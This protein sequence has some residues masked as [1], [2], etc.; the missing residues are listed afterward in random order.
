MQ[1]KLFSIGVVAMFAAV[2]VFALAGTAS[3][4]NFGNCAK[5]KA[6]GEGAGSTCGT[7]HVFEAYAAGEPLSL[8]TKKA[9]ATGNFELQNETT[10]ANGIVCTAL[11]GQGIM[12]NTGGNA[13]SG[14]TLVFEKCKGL[15]ALAFCQ[16]PVAGTAQ[17]LN[18]TEKIEGAVSS[19]AISSTETEVTPT[20][21]N[22]A[23]TGGAEKAGPLGE[24][25]VD[26]GEVTGKIVGHTVAAKQ[27]ELEFNKAKGEK[28]A[29]ENSTQTGTSEQAEAYKPTEKI[30]QK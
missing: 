2:A 14:T 24:T 3:A 17:K 27:N 21:F 16:A 26:L 23:C 7:A 5:A 4:A 6:G 15:G 9:S 1:K 11:S 28:F 18:G 29:G 25:T 8:T 20:G 30:Y 22:I 19:E 10:P 13:V 12:E